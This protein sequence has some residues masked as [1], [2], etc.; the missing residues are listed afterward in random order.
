MNTRALVFDLGGVLIDYRGAEALHD[1]SG[2]RIDQDR[3]VRFWSDA[4]CARDL[5][6]GQ[7]TAEE[8]A[9]Q[10]V[11]ELGLNITS[12]HF[13]SNFQTW[14]HGFY[15]GARELLERLR[16][17]YR[18]ACLSNTNAYDVRRLDEQ[19]EL[20]KWFDACF[21]SNEIGLRKPDPRAYLHVSHA[22]E[23]PPSEI[24]FFDDNLDNVNGA[25]AA[26]MHAHQCLG[27][28]ELVISLHRLGI[29]SGQSNPLMEQSRL[30]GW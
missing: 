14:L 8:F 13:L 20:P 12:E 5:H 6:A 1:L 10:A 18:V 9:R 2:G 15:A 4:Q 11:R 24:V 19:L 25:I 16:P 23:V 28:G 3:F 29:L 22:L 30:R 26:G 27:F 21:Y 7:C 17:Q